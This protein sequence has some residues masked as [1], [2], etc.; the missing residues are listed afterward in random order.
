M[1]RRVV[2][3]S[4]GILA[5]RFRIF[6]TP[7]HLK[8]EN[9]EKVVFLIYPCITFYAGFPQITTALLKPFDTKVVDSNEVQLSG[10]CNSE[11][12]HNLQRGIKGQILLSAKTGKGSN[13]QLAKL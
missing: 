5:S 7:I 3:N 11:M 10:T 6:C 4:F 9:I 12:I 8:V 2:E 1:K 13:S